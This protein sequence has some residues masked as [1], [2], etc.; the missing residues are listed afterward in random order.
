MS[1]RHTST[2]NRCGAV[3]Q[4]A[5]EVCATCC[6]PQ[7]EAVTQS[8]FTAP[9]A[10]ATPA[11]PAVIAAPTVPAGPADATTGLAAW[12]FG[13]ADAEAAAQVAAQA[14]AAD[15]RFELDH[16]SAQRTTHVLSAIPAQRPVQPQESQES[17]QSVPSTG[18]NPFL[19]AARIQNAHDEA[20]L[21]EGY[22]V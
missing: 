15:V 20:A 13:Q 12:P 18:P 22:P 5:A 4:P 2:C 17:L 1:K 14:A 7:S 6:A 21:V 19:A 16:Y 3:L 9:A 11:A 10:P 8:A